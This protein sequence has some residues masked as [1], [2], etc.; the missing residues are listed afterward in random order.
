[1][2]VD[3]SISEMVGRPNRRFGSHVHHQQL[4]KLVVELGLGFRRGGCW[5][6]PALNEDRVAERLG[7]IDRRPAA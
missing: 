5:R 3:Y 2:S 4:R 6:I 1:M 7:L